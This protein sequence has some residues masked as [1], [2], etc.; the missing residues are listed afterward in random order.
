MSELTMP[1]IAGLIT[2]VFLLATVFALLDRSWM[3][4]AF[5]GR[6]CTLF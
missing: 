6:S 5:S 3:L 4:L 1:E 2:I